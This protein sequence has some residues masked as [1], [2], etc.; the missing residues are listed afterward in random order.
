MMMNYGMK[1]AKSKKTKKKM[2]MKKPDKK[3]AMIRK[4][5]KNK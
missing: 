1:K 2:T 4:M 3:V 5:S